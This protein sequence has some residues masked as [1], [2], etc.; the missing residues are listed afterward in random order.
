MSKFNHVYFGEILRVPAQADGGPVFLTG[1]NQGTVSR[2]FLLILGHA[3]KRSIAKRFG[4]G[5]TAQWVHVRPM[6]PPKFPKVKIYMS[7]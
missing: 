7:M 2:G 3:G 6:V 4:Y 1:Y 5:A